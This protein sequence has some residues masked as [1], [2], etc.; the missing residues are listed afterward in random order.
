MKLKALKVPGTSN[1]ALPVAC[2]LDTATLDTLRESLGNALPVA[3]VVHNADLNDVLEARRWVVDRGTKHK[4]KSLGELL[5]KQRRIPV[6]GGS[7][8]DGGQLARSVW[9]LLRRA[10]ECGERNVYI[11]G[12]DAEPFDAFEAKAGALVQPDLS[13]A[14][15]RAADAA[16]ALAPGDAEA[17]SLLSD[18]KCEGVPGPITQ[19][20]IGTSLRMQLVHQLILRAAKVDD[21]VLIL[22]ETGTGKEAVAHFIHEYSDRKSGPFVPVNCA[23]IPANLLESDLFGHLKGA[24]TDAVADKKG[25]W[26]AA[27][28]GTLFLDEIADLHPQHQAK[29]LRVLQDGRIRR[30]GGEQEIKVDARVIAATNQ[31]LV[32]KVQEKAFRE[33]LY[34]RLRSFMIRTPELRGASGDIRLIANAVW[35]DLDTGAPLPEDILA[36]LERQPWPGNVRQLKAVLSNLRNLFRKEPLCARNLRWVLD[37]PAPGTARGRPVDPERVPAL[38]RAECL[39]S[40]RQTA[41]VVRAC[42]VAL[43]PVVIAS[44]VDGAAVR[45]VRDVLHRHIEELELLCLHP[46]LFGSE[47]TFSVVRRLKGQFLYF[48]N[49]L[50]VSPEQARTYWKEDLLAQVKLAGSAVFQEVDRLLK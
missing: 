47:V 49:L 19:A 22:G 36:E 21:P 24:F 5:L 10:R 41:D 30:V 25:L 20:L 3:F 6:I 32:A 11:V 38:H 1:R 31:D 7:Y 34:Y 26:E 42:K 43:R 40:L 46:L 9:T 27:N 15:A 45:A 13:E 37:A 18:L 29:I 35:E 28:K 44:Q 2:E 33:D 23:A 4:A 39:Q 48:H 17:L 50:L 12:S 16:G 8:T 14:T